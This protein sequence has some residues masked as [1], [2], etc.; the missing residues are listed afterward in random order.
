V[1]SQNTG[2]RSGKARL[3]VLGVVLGPALAV[4]LAVGWAADPVSGVALSAAVVSATVAVINL[5]RTPNEQKDQ[6]P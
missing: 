5:C 6:N 2:P 4:G 1:D 3:R